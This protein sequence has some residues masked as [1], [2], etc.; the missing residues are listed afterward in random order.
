MLCAYTGAKHCIVVN[1]GTVSLSIALVA[2]GVQAGDEIIVPDW[3]MVATP[4]AA[5]FIGAVPVFCDVDADTFCIDID[6]ALAMIT[7]R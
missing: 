5:A 4:N 7:P 1:N 6:K 3:T 2:L